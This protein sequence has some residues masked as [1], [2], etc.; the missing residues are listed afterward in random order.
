MRYSRALILL[1][2]I[3]AQTMRSETVFT[4]DYTESQDI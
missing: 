1:H 4:V 3:N 2:V